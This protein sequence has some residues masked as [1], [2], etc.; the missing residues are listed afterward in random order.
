[1]VIIKYIHLNG[2]SLE[3]EYFF[4]RIIREEFA[5]HVIIDKLITNGDEARVIKDDSL[6]KATGFNLAESS[7]PVFFEEEFMAFG[8]ILSTIKSSDKK[9]LVRVAF[10]YAHS[11][12]AEGDAEN[13]V[14]VEESPTLVRVL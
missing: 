12:E 6:S 3:A 10:N 9:E 14:E 7:Y 2:V 4:I 8:E 5:A 1:M 11:A 13:R